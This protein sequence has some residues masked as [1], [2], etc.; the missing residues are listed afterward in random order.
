MAE[1]QGITALAAWMASRPDGDRHKSLFWAGCRAAEEGLEP[2]PLIAAAVA[3]GL[4]RADAERGIADA[5]ATIAHGREEH[6]KVS[7]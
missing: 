7:S 3:A 4:P 5:A 6:E 2:G 1:Q